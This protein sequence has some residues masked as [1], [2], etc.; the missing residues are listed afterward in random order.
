MSVMTAEQRGDMAE[1]LL[2]VAANLVALVHGDG[3]APDV[4]DVLSG[5]SGHEKDGLLVVLAGLVDPDRSLVE[6]LRWVDFDERGEPLRRDPVGPAGSIRES[7]A[8]APCRIRSVG[9]DE[10]AVSRALSPGG[11]DVQ[12]N[13]EERRLA[14]QV[15]VR[16]GMTHAQVGERLGMAKDAVQRSWERWKGRDLPVRSVA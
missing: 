1:A 7:V 2:P 13:R 6:A 9:V 10:V 3:G 16:R 14:I 4:R 8:S 11:A 15:G 12:L 5:L